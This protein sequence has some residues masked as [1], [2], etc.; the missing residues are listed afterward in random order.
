MVRLRA[1][2]A[3]PTSQ[4]T[5]RR[6]QIDV[7][8]VFRHIAMVRCILPLHVDYVQLAK[9]KKRQWLIVNV[10]WE[11]RHDSSDLETNSTN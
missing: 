8:T 1:K 4:K 6:Y 2:G 10:L 5:R 11:V 9:F 3:G 7:L